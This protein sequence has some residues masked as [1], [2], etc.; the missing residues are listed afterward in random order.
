MESSVLSQTEN[1]QIETAAANPGTC[2]SLCITSVLAQYSLCD[3]S[4]SELS[5][6]SDRWDYLLHCV[7]SVIVD[8]R[9][10]LEKRVSCPSLS[11]GWSVRL[12]VCRLDLRPPAILQ[13]GRPSAQKVR[14]N[15]AGSRSE[16]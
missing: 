7:L 6:M 15:R 13:D 3:Y 4:E 16:C 1:A 14:C 12:P 5:V 9:R 10:L 11:T 2:K 8:S